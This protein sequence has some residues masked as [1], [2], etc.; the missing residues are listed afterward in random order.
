MADLLQV[1]LE[2]IFPSHPRASHRAPPLRGA[3]HGASRHSVGCHSGNMASPAEPLGADVAGDEGKAGD[4]TEFTVVSSSPFSRILI[5]DSPVYP[6][7]YAIL[8]D[9]ESSFLLLSESPRLARVRDNW[10]DHRGVHQQLR[11]SGQQLG[12]E[13]IIEGPA[14]LG[15]CRYSGSY[16]RV[17][18]II[19]SNDGSEIFKFSN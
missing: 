9:E 7:Q 4:V 3:V 14:A 11:C 19:G 12:L 8:E 6:T 10:P 16:F 2:A 13:K 17:H 15:T 18:A 1:P 5:P